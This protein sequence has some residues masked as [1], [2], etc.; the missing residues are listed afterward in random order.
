MAGFML[1]FQRTQTK[2]LG[3]TTKEKHHQ[4]NR[5]DHGI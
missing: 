3:N 5:G 4:Q 2:G 1:D